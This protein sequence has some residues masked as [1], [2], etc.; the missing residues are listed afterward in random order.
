MRYK[1][2]VGPKVRSLRPRNGW[3][4]EACARKLG[5]SV[6]YLSQ[7]KANRRPVT[8]P[9]RMGL[10]ETFGVPAETF[11]ADGDQRLLAD[12]REAVAESGSAEGPIPL[13]GLRHG[14]QQPP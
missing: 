9:G 3:R 11:E 12:L 6:S 1:L 4:L 8:D 2:F 14:A 7:I 5:I 13:R 10:I